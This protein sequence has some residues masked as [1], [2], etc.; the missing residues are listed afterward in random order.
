M[1]LGAQDAF[2]ELRSPGPR[3]S[4]LSLV[5]ASPQVCPAASQAWAAARREST[6]LDA[7]GPSSLPSTKSTQRRKASTPLP[8]HPLHK[9]RLWETLQ[10]NSQTQLCRL[11][12]APK[13]A[14]QGHSTLAQLD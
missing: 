8:P 5:R 2:P 12:G 7:G 11:P 4:G 1:C 9:Q 10:A 6:C 13:P 3:D 14:S